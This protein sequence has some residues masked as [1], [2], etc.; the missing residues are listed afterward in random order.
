MPHVF[1]RGAAQPNPTPN[2]E[3]ETMS[4]SRLTVTTPTPNSLVIDAQASLYDNSAQGGA[5]GRH[6]LGVTTT[7]S[8][9]A[10]F[11]LSEAKPLTA[12]A[13]ITYDDTEDMMTKA[14]AGNNWDSWFQSADAIVT[15]GVDCIV[16]WPVE[17]DFDGDGD[18]GAQG[19]VREMGGLDDNPSV[20][21]SYSSGEFMMYQVNATTIYVYE[22]GSNKGAFP[23]RVVVGDRLGIMVVDNVVTYIHIRNDVTT[24]LYTSLKKVEVP[25]YF[26]GAINRGVGSSGHG[27]MGDV[28][29]HSTMESSMLSVYIHGAAAEAIK[30]EDVNRLSEVGLRV[31]TGSTYSYLMVEKGSTYRYPTGAYRFIHDYSVRDSQTI[32][33]I[34]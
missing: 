20:N 15:P 9:L 27:S 22:K 26:K 19:T 29:A 4:E 28:Q 6:S 32:V 21:S 14:N 2:T 13:N 8:T 25:M 31:S 34:Q 18:T 24:V 11:A 5:K 3:G 12:G 16:S 1:K 33:E 17:G 10:P 7:K 23:Q 30:Q